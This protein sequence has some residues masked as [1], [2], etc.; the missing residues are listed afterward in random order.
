M[1]QGAI[2]DCYFFS[3]TGYLA[4]IDPKRIQQMIVPKPDYGFIVHFRDGETFPVP[5]PTEAELL[6]NN[7]ASSLTDGLWLGVLEK[8]LGERMRAHTKSAVKRTAEATDAMAAG[9]HLGLIIE[10]YSGHR[11]RSVALRH[12][13][14]AT[15]IIADLRREIPLVLEKRMLI[16][17]AMGTNPP[18]GQ[19]KVPNLGYKHAYAILGFDRKTDLVTVWNPWGQNFVPKGPEGIEHGFAAQ[20]GVFR[21][22]LATLYHEFSRVFMETNE[23]FHVTGAPR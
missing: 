20:H 21:I 15:A 1:K 8:A 10:L 23:K 5:A 4:A 16:A 22:P 9:G 11:A 14:A 12:P 7:S 2:G 3:V 19:P 6:V 13:R 18:E 17:V